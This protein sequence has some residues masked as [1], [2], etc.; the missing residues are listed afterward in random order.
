M[1]AAR[2]RPAGV[3]V[4]A[5]DVG[6]TAD[7]VENGRT[8]ILVPP[9]DPGALA[10]GLEDLLADSRRREEFGAAARKVAEERLSLHTM[11]EQLVALYEEAATGPKTQSPFRGSR[12]R[13]KA[14]I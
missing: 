3:P 5:T 10:A 4:V 7:L 12:R 13:G 6:G 1:R 14:T 2:E 9:D 8:G 11:V